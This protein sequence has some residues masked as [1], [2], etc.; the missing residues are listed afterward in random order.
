MNYRHYLGVFLV[1]L[2][3]FLP[4]GAAAQA[5][6][7]VSLGDLARSLR[8]SKLPKEPAAPTI[9][10]N[11]NLSQVIAQVESFRLSKTPV[12]SFD[13]VGKQFEVTSPDG[14]CSLSFNANSTALLAT[15]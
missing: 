7:G 8:Q 5:D 1:V 10:D 14:T 15:P 6:D 13:S 9:I 2:G 3:M 11:D 4:V 12:F